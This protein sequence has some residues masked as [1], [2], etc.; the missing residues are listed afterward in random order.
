M[1]LSF[2]MLIK[3]LYSNAE[4]NSERI[5]TPECYRLEI[6]VGGLNLSNLPERIPETINF[7]RV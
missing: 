2:E 7:T 4:Q 6:F 1:K 3:L 5:R